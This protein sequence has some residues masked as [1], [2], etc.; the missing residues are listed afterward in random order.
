MSTREL[1]EKLKIKFETG[2]FTP[3][4]FPAFFDVFSYLGN[5]TEDIQEE[6]E[7]WNRII[8]FEFVGLD[9]FWVQ[10]AE[11]HFSSGS[12]PKSDANLRLSLDADTAVKIFI[13]KKDAEAALNAGELKISGDFP[14][15]ARFYEILELVLGEIEY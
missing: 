1:K 15:A 4:D 11:G 9:S 3:E 6:A 13:G 14:D 12:G 8:E 7:D 10:I 5:E 2:T